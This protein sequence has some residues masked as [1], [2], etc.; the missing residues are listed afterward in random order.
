MYA[1]RRDPHL[2]FAVRDGVPHRLLCDRL[3]VSSVTDIDAAPSFDF[4]GWGL[5]MVRALSDRTWVQQAGP[6]AEWVCASIDFYR[7]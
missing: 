3:P 6:G 7:R 4:G 2:C 1:G 5:V